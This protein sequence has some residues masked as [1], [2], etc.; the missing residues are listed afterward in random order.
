MPAFQNCFVI[1]NSTVLVQFR[2]SVRSLSEKGQVIFIS[3]IFLKFK[4]G[5]A[6]K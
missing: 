4:R 5:K 2:G 3:V 1:L 6:G